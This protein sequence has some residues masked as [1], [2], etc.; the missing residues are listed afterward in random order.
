MLTESLK[1]RQH[2]KTN[3]VMMSVEKMDK[4]RQVFIHH[5]YFLHKIVEYN[6]LVAIMTFLL[7]FFANYKSLD[8]YSRTVGS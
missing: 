1:Q 3:I 5:P 4:N 7:K 8:Y 2:T 6:L